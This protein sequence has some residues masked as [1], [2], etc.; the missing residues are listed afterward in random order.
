MRYLV[1]ALLAILPAAALTAADDAPT[2]KV[3]GTLIIPKD[4]ASFK[5]RVVEVRLYEYDPR[6]ADKAADLVEKVELKDFAHAQGTETKK[7][8][9]VGAKGVLNQMRSYY[10]TLFVLDDK[11]Q[12]THMGEGEHSKNNL[13][14][15]LTNGQPAKITMNVKELKK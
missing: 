12:R 7:E 15:V 13:C 10:V 1:A 6:I 3:E 5:G 2:T 14:K 11:G 4:T 8:F 9:V